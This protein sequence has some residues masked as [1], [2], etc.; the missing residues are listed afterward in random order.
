LLKKMNTLTHS[1]NDDLSKLM[2]Y[3]AMIVLGALA[4]GLAACAK[5][6]PAYTSTTHTT[7]TTGYRK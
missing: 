3:I 1:A 5:D 2:R 6:E 7:S 4:I